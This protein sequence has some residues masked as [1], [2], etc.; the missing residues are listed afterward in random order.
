MAC[1]KR[2]RCIYCGKMYQRDDLVRHLEIKHL[3]ELPDTFTPMRVA[4]HI[5]NKKDFTYRRKCRICGR[6][7][8]WDESKG[9]YNQLC[10]NNNCHIKQANQMYKDMGDRK[11]INSPTQTPEGLEKMLAGRK[12]SGEYKWHDGHVFSYTGSY[13]RA[14]LEFMDKVMEIKYEDLQVPGPVCKYT[15]EGKEHYYIPDMYYIPYNLIIEVK[16]SDGSWRSKNAN[17]AEARAKQIAKEEHIIKNT[18]Y[19]YIRLTGK[20]MS[21]LLIIFTQ[22]KMELVEHTNERVI[23][24]NEAGKLEDGTPNRKTCPKCGG[25]IITMLAAEP[26]RKCKDCGYILGV[27]PLHHEETNAEYLDRMLK[28]SKERNKYSLVTERGIIKSDEQ[29]L[30][31]CKDLM[32]EIISPEDEARYLR[33][34]YASEDGKMFAP[35]NKPITES[36]EILLEVNEKGY[37][38]K[39]TN[40]ITHLMKYKYSTYYQTSNWMETVRRDA[41][42][43]VKYN[44][45]IGKKKVKKPE[46]DQDEIY[47]SARND[48]LKELRE[49]ENTKNV[50]IPLF[51]IDDDFKDIS[52]YDTVEEINRFLIRNQQTAEAKKYIDKGLESGKMII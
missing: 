23:R 41:N 32:D 42:D 40:I 5:A 47:I 39:L 9:R 24:V 50:K 27:V 25:K 6:P 18:D 44:N 22:L 3:D 52:R 48:A 12:I 11:G 1:N 30:Q 51:D 8:S 31:E 33:E 38:T 20:D 36:T 49:H 43:L 17:W 35:K 46:I 26:V 10:D 15:F 7:T 19:N 14:A 34:F 4:Y 37:K 29:L 2:Y 21:Q 45:K 16:D 13:E 28:E